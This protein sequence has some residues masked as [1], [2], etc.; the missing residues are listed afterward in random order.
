[1]HQQFLEWNHGCQIIN[2]DY[3]WNYSNSIFLS[4]WHLYQ[5]VRKKVKWY[6]FVYSFILCGS[7]DA[8][9]YSSGKSFWNN[10]CFEE[11]KR[12]NDVWTYRYSYFLVIFG[13]LWGRK[14]TYCNF[15]FFLIILFIFLILLSICLAYYFYA[16]LL[17]HQWEFSTL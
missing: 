3:F 1:M 6:V 12:Y 2:N 7:T 16:F 17:R 15:F 8:R 10:R 11:F 4:V 13:Y 14:E 9:V 5:C